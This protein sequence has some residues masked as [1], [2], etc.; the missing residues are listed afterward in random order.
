MESKELQILKTSFEAHTGLKVI[1]PIEEKLFPHF[2]RLELP[3]LNC[4]EM[5][6]VMYYIM[7]TFTTPNTF[8]HTR[9]KLHSYNNKLVL[10]VDIKQIQKHLIK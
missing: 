7:S 8:E 3:Q 5:Y 4:V 1:A 10:T 9:P 2:K 6:K